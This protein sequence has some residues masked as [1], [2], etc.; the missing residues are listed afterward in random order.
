MAYMNIAAGNLY[1]KLFLC[2]K[3]SHLSFRCK[4]VFAVYS[5]WGSWSPFLIE[6]GPAWQ[7]GKERGSKWKIRGVTGQFWVW[8]GWSRKNPGCTYMDNSSAE[9]FWILAVSCFWCLAEGLG[10]SQDIF[11]ISQKPSFHSFFKSN[12]TVTLWNR[13]V[14]GM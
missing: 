4:R 6:I 8:R 3:Y 7:T 9:Q 1:H 2:Q 13:T 5:Q 14:N 11:I 10:M 12:S